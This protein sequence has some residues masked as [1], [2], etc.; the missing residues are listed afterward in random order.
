MFTCLP[1][2]L[3]ASIQNDMNEFFDKLLD[4]LE[5]ATSVDY[6]R[7]SEADKGDDTDDAR[8][9]KWKGVWK[10]IKENVFQGEIVYQKELNDTNGDSC[11][12]IQ[13]MRKEDFSRLELTVGPRFAD[14]HASL[15]DYFETQLFTGDNKIDCSVCEQKQNMIRSTVLGRAPST[16]VLALKRY[17]L[18]FE[19]FEHVK[20]NN[21]MEFPVELNMY[22]YTIEGKAEAARLAAMSHGDGDTGGGTPALTPG[23][24]TSGG[25]GY[26]SPRSSAPPSPRA[27]LSL[28]PRQRRSHG[29]LYEDGTDIDGSHTP[30]MTPGR[31]V[32]DGSGNGP[33]S[34]YEYILQGVLVH[35]GV[36]GGGHYYSFGE[37]PKEPTKWH[38][39]D[40]EMVTTFGATPSE[41]AYE[42]FGGPIGGGDSSS[43]SSAGVGMDRTANALVLFYRRKGTETE[44][45][46]TDYAKRGNFKK[47]DKWK[48]VNYFKEYKISLWR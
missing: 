9:I 14:L 24:G 17:I 45:E 33:G 42:C 10:Q 4:K 44:K 8:S 43:S 25:S 35:A 21:R 26:N 34:L 37:N 12:H 41:L 31:S 11:G 1:A 40:D 16:L 15:D 19:T 48:V 30:P 29:T 32:D 7:A 3:P 28:S 36:A 2:C 38:R 5:T 6:I 18:D 39:Y 20:L 27:S 46:A 23:G 22:R 13:E 47:K